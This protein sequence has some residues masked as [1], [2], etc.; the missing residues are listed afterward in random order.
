LSRGPGGLSKQA[1]IE[2][3]GVAGFDNKN[4]SRYFLATDPPDSDRLFLSEDRIEF[5]GKRHR[6]ISE[7]VTHLLVPQI[8]I[9]ALAG[10][11]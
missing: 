1:R 6:K 9:E 7:L 11:F 5:L 4:Y 2:P 3:Q 8:Q 10:W